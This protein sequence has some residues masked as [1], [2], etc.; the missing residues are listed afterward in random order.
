MRDIWHHA[1]CAVAA[2][3][4][5]R[6]QDPRSP[7]T[8]PYAYYLNAGLYAAYLRDYVEA[9][10][11]ERIE[12]RIADVEQRSDDGLSSRLS[13]RTVGGSRASCSST[14]RDSAA[15]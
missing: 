5:S 2:G 8:L 6:E 13:W 11:V 10:G 7:F 14:V 15:C 3:R 9:R 12:G 4:F 1:P